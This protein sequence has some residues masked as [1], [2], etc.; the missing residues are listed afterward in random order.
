MDKRVVPLIVIIIVAFQLSFIYGAVPD[1]GENNTALGQVVDDYKN[2]NSVASTYNVINNVTLDCM[3]IN[4]TMSVF[5]PVTEN[6]IGGDWIEWGANIGKLSQTN[7]R[8]IFVNLQQVDEAILYKDKDYEGSYFKDFMHNFTFCITDISFATTVNRYNA[9]TIGNYTNDQRW[10]IIGGHDL[11]ALAIMGTV[12]NVYYFRVFEYDGSVYN[13]D[14]TQT[15]SEDVV[16]YVGIVKNGVDFSVEI[17]TDALYQNL[18]DSLYVTLHHDYV[19]RYLHVPQSF[20]YLTAND[21]IDGYVEDLYIGRGN[22]T[23]GYMDGHYYTENIM[24]NATGGTLVHLTNVTLPANTG[25]T[26]E[27]SNDNTTWRNHLNQ[28]GSDDLE[29]DY[30]ALDMRNLNYTTLY[31]RFNMT[32]TDSS[33]TPRVYQSRIITTYTLASLGGMKFYP[34]I[35][36]GI[37]IIFLITVS[38]VLYRKRR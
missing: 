17:Y 1:F 15:F 13:Y 31:I 6:F 14:T 10:Y 32:T 19:M 30:Y 11:L 20:D 34:I 4:Y 24:L 9:W 7:S 2:N 22:M 12:N 23:G 26:T 21:D 18:R 38:L 29:A 3:E 8:S 33:V 36:Y 27:Y 28:V 5:V 37:A 35:I 16:Y 25:I